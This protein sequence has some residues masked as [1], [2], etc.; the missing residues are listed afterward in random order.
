MKNRN[1]LVS[2]ILSLLLS[3]LGQVYNGELKKGIL[4]LLIIFPIYLILGLTGI[5]SSFTGLLIISAVL[6]IYKLFVSI[7]AYRK[8][9][10]L[11]PYELKPINQVWKYILFAVLGYATVQVGM[12]VN[13]NLI[14]YEAFTIPTVSMEP[15]INTGDKV[16]ATKVNKETIQLG[17]LITFT[18]EDG[19]KYLSRVVGLPKQEI[20]VVN[21]KVIYDESSEEW[22][23]TAISRDE[24]YEFQ[25][26]QSQLPNG[27]K[28]NVKKT[29][30]YQGRELPQ[31]NH[32]N[33]ETQIV[34][35]NHVFVMGDNRNNTMDSR[36]YGTIPLANIDKKVNYIWWSKEKAQIGKILSE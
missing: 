27:R 21:D 36:V 9:K 8:A 6:L 23:K 33:V 12:T 14:G 35:D 22:T 30:K 18:R 20:Q 16:M 13:R 28:F 7:E 19:Q 4:F 15:T 17:D 32:S 2:F 24:D 26:Y 25:E 11:N 31:Q 1:P 29:L 10:Q 3:G 5:V 34:P